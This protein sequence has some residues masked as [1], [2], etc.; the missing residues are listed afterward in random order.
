MNVD[1]KFKSDNI[2]ITRKL[3][4]GATE[5]FNQQTYLAITKYK[6]GHINCIKYDS[7]FSHFW[8]GRELLPH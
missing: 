1:A 3:H 2:L 8:F 7:P 5:A 6:D 4:I